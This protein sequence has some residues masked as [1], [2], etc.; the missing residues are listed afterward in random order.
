LYDGVDEKV[1]RIL[2][3]WYSN[4]VCYVRWNDVVSS[5]FKM[6]NGTRQGDVFSPLLF[7]RYIRELLDDVCSSG[8]GCFIGTQCVN[9]LAYADDLVL[10]APSWHA[11][12]SMLNILHIQSFAIDL[13][14]NVTKTV[15]M[16]FMRKS[17]HRIFSTVFPLLQLAAL[18]TI[19][20]TF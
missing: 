3:F 5:G 11:L 8:I 14:C 1:V 17:R 9:I 6:G 15:Y 20:F 19:C 10:L 4:E 12:Q 18:L 13:T 16:I 2:A 7:S